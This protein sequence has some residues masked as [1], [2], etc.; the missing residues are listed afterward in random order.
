[1]QKS[2][3]QP[4]T[5]LKPSE[6]R[7][8]RFARN[9]QDDNMADWKKV[10]KDKADSIN[11]LIPEGW[12]ISDVPSI[13]QQ[14]DVTGAFIQQYLDKK[15]IEITETDAVGIVEKT[16][17]GVW[18]AVE[19]AK[20]FCHRAAVAHQLVN[21]LH[22]IFFDAAI[23]DAEKVDKY[24]QEHKKP[25]G[26]LHGLPVSLKDQFHVKGVETHMAV[27]YTHLTLPTKR[28]V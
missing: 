15:E 16:S 13:E 8:K 5:Y 18:S 25:I 10:A 19:V 14:R 24:Y 12:R 22:E 17:T 28:I 2:S 9:E 11:A 26:A 23:A 6:W 20:A 21:C 27:S 1:M 4:G 7:K 3:E